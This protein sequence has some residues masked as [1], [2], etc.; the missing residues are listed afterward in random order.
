LH[1]LLQNSGD[2]DEIW[3]TISWINLLQRYVNIYHLIWVI[4]LHYLVKLKMFIT[5]VLPQHCQ[6]KKLQNLSHLNCGGLQIRQIWIQLITACGNTAREGVQNTHHWS[7]WT[8][9]ATEIMSS[10][11]QPFISGVVDSYRSLKRVLHT[12]LAIF[13]TQCY[14]LD[15]NLV[16]LQATV[17]VG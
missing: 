13:P 17:E 8:E 12:S 7:G 14:Q 10:L 15:S 16:N 4:S 11:Q 3:Y 6:R 9:T 5:Q 2:S 1:Y